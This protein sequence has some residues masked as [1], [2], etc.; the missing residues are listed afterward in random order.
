M[1]RERIEDWIV[2][3]VLSVGCFTLL[4]AMA[5]RVLQFFGLI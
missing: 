2:V 5:G 4:A 3:A 1:N